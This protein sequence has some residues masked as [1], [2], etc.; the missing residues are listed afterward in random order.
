MTAPVIQHLALSPS[1][2]HHV[3]RIQQLQPVTSFCTAHERG[4]VLHFLRVIRSFLKKQRR[5]CNRHL[6]CLQRLNYLPLALYRKSLPTL[7][8][9][10][11]SAMT[12]LQRGLSKI[13]KIVNHI[14]PHFK[15]NLHSLVEKTSGS[16]L[17]PIHGSPGCLHCPH[18][19]SLFQNLC[20]SQTKVLHPFKT[21][22]HAIPAFQMSHHPSFCLPGSKHTLITSLSKPFLHST[23]DRFRFELA[24]LFPVP[25]PLIWY[26]LPLIIF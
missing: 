9:Y 17:A 23:Q 1:C 19:S 20:H 8:S 5:I 4:L 6:R 12:T 7:P 16:S 11:Y 25:L 21:F 26:P 3:S 14:T 18:T 2:W 10:F 22:T 15:N 13:H 24:D